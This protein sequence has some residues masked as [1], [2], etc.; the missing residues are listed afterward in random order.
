MG[1]DGYVQWERSYYGVTWTWAGQIVQ[2]AAGAD[3]VEIWAGHQRLAVHPRSLQPGKRFALPNQWE[4]LGIGDGRPRKEAL[5]SQLPMPE[6]ERRSL[7]AYEALLAG[8][9]R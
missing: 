1:R 7:G 4:G 6:V 2:V 5:A 3:V 9:E 8:G